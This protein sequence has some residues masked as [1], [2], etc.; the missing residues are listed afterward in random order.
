VRAS[1]ARVQHSSGMLFGSL[2]ARYKKNPLLMT[3]LSSAN[4]ISLRNREKYLIPSTL[5]LREGG[6]RAW[7][8]AQ[9]LTPSLSEPIVDCRAHILFIA[10]CCFL[11][12]AQFL[13]LS[14]DGGVYFYSTPFLRRYCA[15]TSG[16]VTVIIWLRV[17]NGIFGLGVRRCDWQDL[18]HCG[19]PPLPPCQSLIPCL[20]L[21]DP[22]F[23]SITLEKEEIVIH[24][25][26]LFNIERGA[27]D[28]APLSFSHQLYHDHV[29]A[30]FC[31]L[32]IVSLITYTFTHTWSIYNEFIDLLLLITID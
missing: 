31:L 11:C 24:A 7:I 5:S 27:K 15:F 10:W 12:V 13:T 8:P 20:S 26:S 9:V 2:M 16:D 28:S 29:Y 25:P 18:R 1:R 21:S 23:C 4:Q 22:S 19:P 17:G 3:L 32:L 30:N 6:Q 14:G